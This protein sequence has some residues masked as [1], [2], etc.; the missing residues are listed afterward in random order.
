MLPA[1]AM[2]DQAKSAG[3]APDQRPPI[4]APLRQ[5]GDHRLARVPAR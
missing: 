5:V 4:M 1:L 2:M 3:G